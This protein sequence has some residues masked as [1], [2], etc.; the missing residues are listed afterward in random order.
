M[1]ESQP[2]TDSYLRHLTNYEMDRLL[3]EK[4]YRA[5]DFLRI[6]GRRDPEY[7]A[8]D[9]WAHTRPDQRTMCRLPPERSDYNL[10]IEV[11]EILH[12]LYPDA[13]EESI[14]V[15][16][17]QPGRQYEARSRAMVEYWP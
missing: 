3:R 4:S 5:D 12:N 17:F 7:T 6:T 1:F 16:A 14:H 15:M 10:P 11:H 8:V 2:K 9:A 13:P